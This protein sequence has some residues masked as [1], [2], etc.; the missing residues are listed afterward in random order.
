LPA[1]QS[2]IDLVIYPYGNESTELE[3]ILASS[4]LDANPYK[5]K[6]FYSNSIA[7][8]EGNIFIVREDTLEV[9]RGDDSDSDFV[10]PGTTLITRTDKELDTVDYE[11]SLNNT[12][13][14]LQPTGAFVPGYDYYYKIDEVVDRASETA[15]NL[16]DNSNWFEGKST[17]TFELSDIILDNNN[18]FNEGEVIRASNTAGTLVS[19]SSSSA[20]VY[21]FL[22]LSIR[23]LENFT[24]SKVLVVDDGDSESTSK[25]YD[26]IDDGEVDDPSLVNTVSTASNENIEGVSTSDIYRGTS[27]ADGRYYRLNL[28]EQMDDHTA[29]NTN[30]VTFE[31]AYNVA[32]GE[33]QTGNITLE[34]Q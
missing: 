21:L 14:T 32:G 30:T 11:L 3:V 20:S 1:D 22:P 27:L 24:L 12:L 2:G 15:V 23:S 5:Y 8:E 16:E 25:F 19:S 18:Y 33:V 26:I 4:N 6:V 13:L 34:V 29:T 28:Y 7:I 9:V 10:L 17:D 31:Y